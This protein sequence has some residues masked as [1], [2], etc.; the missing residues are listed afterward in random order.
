MSVAFAGRPL[1]S[2]RIARRQTFQFAVRG[3]EAR[4]FDVWNDAVAIIS[5]MGL[6]GL[7]LFMVLRG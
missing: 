5:M 3:R 4:G 2:R 7:F 6:A 1:A